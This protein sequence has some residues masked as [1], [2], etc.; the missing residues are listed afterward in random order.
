MQ[1][2]AVPGRPDLALLIN[3]GN[4][5]SKSFRQ[6]ILLLVCCSLHY[7]GASWAINDP[8]DD[9]D[10]AFTAGQFGRMAEI[11]EQK[12]GSDLDLARSDQLVRLCF[13]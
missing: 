13:A 1:K 8:V 5:M 4:R 11:L 9:V 10:R 6:M 2:Q 12:I 7:P 3:R